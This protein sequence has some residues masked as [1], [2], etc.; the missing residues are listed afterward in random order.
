MRLITVRLHGVLHHYDSGRG[1]EGPDAVI[2]ESL[3]PHDTPDHPQWP[4]EVAETIRDR[5]GAEIVYAQP[6]EHR[7]GRVY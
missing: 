4:R 7:R 2:L 6:R 1:W 5:L 3:T